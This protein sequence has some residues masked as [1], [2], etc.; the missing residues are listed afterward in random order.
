MALF[1]LSVRLKEST[2]NL[3][4]EWVKEIKAFIE[5]IAIGIQSNMVIRKHPKETDRFDISF[6]VGD[7]SY[8]PGYIT[9]YDLEH[10]DDCLVVKLY[11][12]DSKEAIVTCILPKDRRKFAHWLMVTVNTFKLKHNLTAQLV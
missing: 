5:L 10:K 4:E 7:D 2:K 9:F 12:H 8:S 1:S 11:D 3:N 6:A